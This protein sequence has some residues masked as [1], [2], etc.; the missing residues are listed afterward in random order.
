MTGEDYRHLDLDIIAASHLTH[1]ISRTNRLRN[2]PPSQNRGKSGSYRAF[3]VYYTASETVV[4]VTMLS[5]G[6]AENLTRQ[7]INEIGKLIPLLEADILALY[8]KPGRPS[9]EKDR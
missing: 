7:Q 3:Y 8:G 5:K 1:V 4:A 6:E 2:A 9:K